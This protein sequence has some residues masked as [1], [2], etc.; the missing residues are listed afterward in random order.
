VV[1][2]LAEGDAKRVEEGEGAEAEDMGCFGAGA[3]Y[4]VA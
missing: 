3:G 4:V 1:A 2:A